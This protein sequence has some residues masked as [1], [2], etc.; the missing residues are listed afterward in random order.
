MKALRSLSQS[1]I[2]GHRRTPVKQPTG[3]AYIDLKISPKSQPYPFHA[4]RQ[5]QHTHADRRKRY[6]SGGTP[7]GKPKPSQQL[8]SRHINAV[9]REKHLVRGGRVSDADCK[10]IDQIG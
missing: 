5:E 2:D 3:L 10:E 7:Q 6:Q 8:G 1:D 9:T 4:Q